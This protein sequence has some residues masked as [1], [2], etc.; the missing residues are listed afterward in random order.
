MVRFIAV[1]TFIPF[2]FCVNFAA[3]GAQQADQAAEDLFRERCIVCHAI[4]CNRTGPKL[5]GVL[6]R[7][8]GSVPD[9]QGYSNGLKNA[10]WTW[11]EEMVGRWITDPKKLVADTNMSGGAFRKV[12]KS[13]ERNLLIQ[14]IK[15][16]DTSLDLCGVRRQ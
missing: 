16:G 11:N 13:E 9:F 8:A 14:F 10:S 12:E 2:A 3:R 6:G 7:K 4:G 5:G 15:R 1:A